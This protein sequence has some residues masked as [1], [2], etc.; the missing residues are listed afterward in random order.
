MLL[1][2]TLNYLYTRALSLLCVS[3]IAYYNRP[4][5][6]EVSRTR[7]AAIKVTPVTA[8]RALPELA[9]A[10]I[11]RR[12]RPAEQ[13]QIADCRKWIPREKGTVGTLRSM[14]FHAGGEHLIIFEQAS[15]PDCPRPVFFSTPP[16]ALENLFHLPSGFCHGY[17][18]AHN[19]RCVT[20]FRPIRAPRDARF[21]QARKKIRRPSL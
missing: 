13:L 4:T 5:V 11:A 2:T 8:I 12:V 16:L 6:R 10:P 14:R 19:Q 18:H 20:R 7:I 9:V 15:F 21:A 17:R 3:Q 1:F